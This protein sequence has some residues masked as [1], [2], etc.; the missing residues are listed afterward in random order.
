MLNSLLR[1]SCLLDAL[2]NVLLI[3]AYFRIFVLFLKSKYLMIILL[4]LCCL[5]F[6]ISKTMWF[7]IN[8][9]VRFL[10]VLDIF[11]CFV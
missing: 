3:I 1:I 8:S 9:S 7:I 11:V 2:G 6:F 10:L 4:L 5:I